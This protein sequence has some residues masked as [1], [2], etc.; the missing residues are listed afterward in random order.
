MT[1]K[2][3]PRPNFLYVSDTTQMSQVPLVHPLL[4]LVNN[5][6]N[7][8]IMM[9]PWLTS[10]MSC[11]YLSLVI[12]IYGSI[13][14]CKE[15]SYFLCPL[16]I[17][18]LFLDGTHPVGNV[19]TLDFPSLFLFIDGTHHVGNVRTLDFPSLFLFIDGT[20]HVGNVRTLDF[21]SLFLFIDGTHH[22]GHARTLY[23][24]SL[25]VPSSSHHL[26]AVPCSTP[27]NRNRLG[28][29]K[30]RTFPTWW[31]PSINRNRG[32]FVLWISPVY[33]YLSV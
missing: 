5:C 33:F 20:H 2:N 14:P 24:P 19:R 28:K 10:K 16:Y 8:T 7:Q 1:L 23:F 13:L 22:V 31:V 17:L 32:M 30:V 29:S 15:C 3:T 27:I 18:F 6:E 9:R 11:K 25:S 12:S 21:P 26:D 4:L